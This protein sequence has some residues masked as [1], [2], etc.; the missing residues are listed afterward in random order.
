MK[1]HLITVMLTV[2]MFAM[3]CGNKK[4]EP[5]PHAVDAAATAEPERKIVQVKPINKT[6]E[7]KKELEKALEKGEQRNLRALETID[8]VADQ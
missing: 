2:A 4:E 7:F 3:A 5:A 8:N 6:Q 1:T